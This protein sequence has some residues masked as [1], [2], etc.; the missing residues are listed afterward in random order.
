MAERVTTDE[1]DE[2]PLRTVVVVS[3]GRDCVAAH[4]F[5]SVTDTAALPTSIGESKG[6]LVL[7]VSAEMGHLVL[8][9]AVFST[10][11]SP[12]SVRK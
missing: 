2:L 1:P 4:V 8:A 9:I 3:C 11:Q 5:R 12:I 7:L 6:M 10:L